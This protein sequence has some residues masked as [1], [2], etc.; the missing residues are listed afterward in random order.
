MTSK[1]VVFADTNLLLQCKPLEE[2]D[3]KL[4]GHE[5]DVDVLI[6][7]PVQAELDE[8]KGRGNARQ[9]SRARAALSRLGGLLESEDDWLVLRE[10][11]LVRLTVSLNLD[12]DPSKADELR[13]DTRDGQLVG[14]GLKYHR[15]YPNQAVTLVSA[16]FGPLLSAKRVALPFKKV[17]D[18]WKLA[19]EPDD[20]ARREA[21]LK[22]QIELLQNSEPKFEIRVEDATKQA[23]QVRFEMY[24]P[25]SANEMEEAMQALVSEHPEATEFGPTEPSETVVSTE[26]IFSDMYS[27]E[28]DVFTP[29]TAEQISK[30][31][32]SYSAWK[33]RCREHLDGVHVHLNKLLPWP[34]LT[35]LIENVG[36][37]PAEDAL[38]ELEARGPFAI[39]RPPKKKDQNE[40]GGSERS[41]DLR[42]PR[43]PQAPKGRIERVRTGPNFNVRKA[44]E[45]LANARSLTN[46]LDDLNRTLDV[47]FR[48]LADRD[49]NAFYWDSGIVDGHPAGAL[50]L[51]CQQWRHARSVERFTVGLMF[52]REPGTYSGSLEVA[53]HAA[54]LSAPAKLVL[55]V[56]FVVAEV[57]P[58]GE[59][60]KLIAD[61]A[62]PSPSIQLSGG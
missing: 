51:R 25:L 52:R 43:P 9:A 45:V 24:A 46:Y 16:D 4:I 22:K 1:L 62:K 5:G 49:P 57:S 39:M 19:P 6:T 2:L 14:I 15:D 21:E 58:S 40:S 36:S 35:A 17:P 30:Y 32:Q 3:W 55:P 53:V 10:R 8:L 54:N 28:K 7:R 47:P 41:E 42:L 12:V 33:I 61:L 50:T 23:H 60:K 34:N 26:G 27:S 11:P 38:V 56:K 20:S 13:Y 31:R 18:D 59:V 29:A 44:A 48:P 37:R